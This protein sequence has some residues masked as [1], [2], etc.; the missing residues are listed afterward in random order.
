MM[1]SATQMPCGVNDIIALTARLAQVLAQEADLLQEMKVSKIADLQKE[2]LVLT[3][4][5]EMQKKQLDKNPELIQGAT[6]EERE[7]LRSVIG[8]F[9]T[10]LAEN[11]RRLLM[12]KEVNQRIVEA[13]TDVV[14]EVS[15]QGVYNDKGAPDMVGRDALS[16]TLNKTI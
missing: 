8:I 5:L 11:H 3:A 15:N 9:D 16:V 4:A 7:D 6:E 1:M 12:A 13:I 10:I 2:K 14:T